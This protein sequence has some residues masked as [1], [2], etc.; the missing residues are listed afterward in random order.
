VSATVA[1][2]FATLQFTSS[3]SYAVVDVHSLT[4][5]F[6]ITRAFTANGSHAVSINAGSFT[7]RIYNLLD[8]PTGAWTI[9]SNP[10]PLV[11]ALELACRLAR[12]S[13]N[14]TTVVSSLTNRI[15]TSEWVGYSNSILYFNP[16][17]TF[18]YNPSAVRTDIITPDEQTYDLAQY[19]RSLSGTVAAQQCNDASIFLSLHGQALGV[20]VNPLHVVANAGYSLTTANAYAAGTD[21]NRRYIAFNFHQISTFS[22]F[23]YD[24][25]VASSSAHDAFSARTAEN[26]ISTVF[27]GLTLSNVMTTTVTTIHLGNVTPLNP[28]AFTVWRV[29]AGTL[30]VNGAAGS[31][32]TV[33][34]HIY[35]PDTITNV[36]FTPSTTVTPVLGIS[37][38][39]TA[40]GSQSPSVGTVTFQFNVGSVTIP[41]QDA[42]MEITPHN[43]PLDPDSIIIKIR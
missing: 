3:G 7:N 17:G 30:S 11:E 19:L 38:S 22:G 4:C 1:G 15:H 12:A 13:N 25:A 42:Q 27:P 39:V 21:V 26:Y 32:G 20:D 16:T 24:A 8:T 28:N 2:G 34:L 36:L 43:S 37:A 35:N 23:V 14:A 18:V 10:R 33:T 9:P 6:V 5:H 41:A 40:F 29:L 31:T